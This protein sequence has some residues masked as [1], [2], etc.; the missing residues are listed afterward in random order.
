MNRAN[1]IYLDSP[2]T[3]SQITYAIYWKLYG[4]AESGG[5]ILNDTSAIGTL[6]AI[7]VLA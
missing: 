5:F 3:T 4:A 7:E 6:T 2:S 1:F